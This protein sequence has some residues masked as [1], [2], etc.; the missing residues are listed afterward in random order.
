MTIKRAAPPHQRKRGQQHSP[1]VGTKTKVCGARSSEDGVDLALGWRQR[2]HFYTALALSLSLLVSSVGSSI[3]AS[4][5][6]VSSRFHPFKQV[7]GFLEGLI[8]SHIGSLRLLCF[9][10][11]EEHVLWQLGFQEFVV[12]DLRLV[13]HSVF[14]FGLGR[15]CPSRSP[16]VVHVAVAQALPILLSC[17]CTNSSLQLS[18]FCSATV[19]IRKSPLMALARCRAKG[20]L[21]STSK[22]V[23]KRDTLSRTHSS[24]VVRCLGACLRNSWSKGARSGLTKPCSV[25]PAYSRWDQKPLQAR[26]FSR[27]RFTFFSLAK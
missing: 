5:G 18:L 10:L 22:L 24:R 19:S 2:S 21:G 12:L 15:L 11:C 9:V 23:R 25:L 13:V 27:I 7:S 17:P 20:I 26:S 4:V 8:C 3:P 14:L 16:S 6:W 1:F